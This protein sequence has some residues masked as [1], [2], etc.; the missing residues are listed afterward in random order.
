MDQLSVRNQKTVSAYFT[1]KQILPSGLAGPFSSTQQT[2]HV[3]QYRVNA[4]DDK[5]VL[6][7]NWLNITSL[8]GE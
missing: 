1:S 3:D 4:M 8:L 7:Q 6:S 2:G 5:P